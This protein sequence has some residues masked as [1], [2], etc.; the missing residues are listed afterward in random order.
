MTLCRKLIYLLD[1]RDRIRAVGLLL[2][3]LLGALFEAAG[4]ALV[5]PFLSLVSDPDAV[6]RSGFLQSMGDLFGLSG[7]RDLLILCGS[8]LLAITVVKT[9]YLTLLFYVQNRFIFRKQ[10][11][12]SRRLFSAYLFSPY[13][14]HLRRNSAELLR[15]AS[16]D[17]L[18]VFTQIMVPLSYIL[19]EAMVVAVLLALLIVAA[20][21][22]ALAALVLI[23]GLGAGS[24]LLA[25]RRLKRAGQRY[26]KQQEA[27]IRWVHQGLGS[28]KE[29]KVLG[30]EEFFAGAYGR[31]ALDNA[32]AI[33]FL[34]FASD[35]PR[36][37]MEGLVL[38]G[39]F[40]VLLFVLLS[41]RDIQLVLPTLGLFAVAAV[42][43]MPSAS[44]ILTALTTIRYYRTALDAVYDDLRELAEV[45]AERATATG[46][47]ALGKLELRE[48]LTL[49]GV[50]YRYDGATAPALKEISLS[51][52]RGESVGFVGPSG[53]GKTTLI[54]VLLGLLTPT[55]GRVLVDD[56]DMA[57]RLSA[58][59]RLVGYIPQ[60]VY[61]A[62][63]TI[64]RNVAFGLS[65]EAI[66]ESRV[67]EV[68][69]SAQ[70]AEFG[71]GLPD[72][73]RTV[74]GEHGA[75]LSGGQRQR[76][77]IARALYRD[78]QLLVLD[79]AMAALDN[80][81]EREVTRAIDQLRGDKTIITIAHRLST[82]RH[83]DRL[84]FLEA[85][86]I[87]AEGGYDELIESDD[88]FR[89]MALVTG[90]QSAP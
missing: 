41:G 22:A 10:A 18:W 82:V 1:R 23:G 90:K 50:S 59:Q 28:I 39:I 38:G 32:R 4:V 8:I 79:E 78:P 49:D 69:E 47:A 12:V 35:T 52:A 66:D 31:S 56:V 71:R 26:Q 30:V 20:P 46:R 2:M 9:L 80:V 55:D 5:F 87:T 17:V 45:E 76:L 11:E 77:G 27:M 70:L 68:L 15:K 16:Y 84:Y 43:L 81:T 37:A 21:G 74:I 67:W 24:Q 62:D 83:C 86:R 42:R 63:D 6:E 14:F 33:R 64:L 44:R 7:S 60:P 29:T 73:I 75:R 48:S 40:G 65:D 54:D 34:R 58:W 57:G 25:R 72:G 61:L 13:T 88:A 89:R 3:M 19:V 51:I 85:G 53:A 36:V